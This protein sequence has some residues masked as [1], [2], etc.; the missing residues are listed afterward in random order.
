MKDWSPTIY[1]KASAEAEINIIES[2]SY[3]I[4]RVIDDLRA[5]PYGTGSLR[6]TQL[7]FDASGSYFDMDMSMLETG[8]MYGIR[9]AYYN[10]SV[11]DWVEQTEKFKF[12]V[13]D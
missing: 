3:E 8:Y 4:Y 9:L 5:V 10:E 2:G 6:H 13:G 1:T 12:R 11:G 7:S